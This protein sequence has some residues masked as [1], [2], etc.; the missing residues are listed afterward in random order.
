MVSK[1][2]KQTFTSVFKSHSMPYSYGFV[3]NLNKKI[4][5]NYIKEDLLPHREFFF[6]LFYHLIEYIDFFLISL[7]IPLNY[8]TYIYRRSPHGVVATVLEC[9]HEVNKFD[10]QSRG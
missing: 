5:V 4:L 3:P 10:L 9:N 2:D 8:Y 1:L 6:F 7:N